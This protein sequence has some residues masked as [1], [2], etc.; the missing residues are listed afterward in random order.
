MKGIIHL[1]RTQNWFFQTFCVCT[2]WMTPNWLSRNVLNTWHLPLLLLVF[3][4][5]V[6]QETC[7]SGVIA[8]SVIKIQ[9]FTLMKVQ[10]FNVFYKS[11]VDLEIQ[12]FKITIKFI[13]IKFVLEKAVFIQIF[14]KKCFFIQSPYYLLTLHISRANFLPFC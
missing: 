9:V 12:N 7:Y 2:K 1:V 8:F 11:Y 4:I 13:R 10:C 14:I 6:Q 3:F 5:T